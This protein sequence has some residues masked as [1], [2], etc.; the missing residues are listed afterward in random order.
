MSRHPPGDRDNHRAFCE[1]EGW[2]VRPSARGRAGQDHVKY[3]LRLDDGCVLLTRI[4]HP[5][6]RTTYG[7]SMWTHILRDQLDV[8]EDEFWACVRDQ[9]LPGRSR[10][11]ED[12][13]SLPLWLVTHLL[14]AGVPQDEVAALDEA[15][16]RRRIAQIW[17]S[18]T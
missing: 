2:Q 8:T 1:V 12:M 7:R 5:V 6:D 15:Q 9:V 10:P 13:P 11:T 18:E 3:E 16:A 17:S 4:S 14:E